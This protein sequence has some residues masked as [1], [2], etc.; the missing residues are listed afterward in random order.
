MLPTPYINCFLHLSV[1]KPCS[2]TVNMFVSDKE[3]HDCA[4]ICLVHTVRKYIHVHLRVYKLIC[5]HYMHM[6]MYMYLLHVQ[7][8][9]CSS[10]VTLACYLMPACAYYMHS[11]Y[12]CMCIHTMP[13]I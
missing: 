13:T 3:T 11:V 5:I 7:F 1:D 8:N 9:L 10:T 2:S 4:I 12:V 6:F